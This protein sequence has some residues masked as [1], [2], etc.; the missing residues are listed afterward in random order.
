MPIFENWAISKEDC[1]DNL[2]DFINCSR[3]SKPYKSEARK[4]INENLI[5]FWYAYILMDF[6]IALCVAKFDLK[7][8]FSWTLPCFCMYFFK[9]LIISKERFYTELAF[10]LAYLFLSLAISWSCAPYTLGICFL[11]TLAHSLYHEFPQKLPKSPIQ[12]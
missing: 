1:L 8:I 12:P 7:D 10:M 9:R 5:Q 3:F 2:K 6:A 4:R 11:L